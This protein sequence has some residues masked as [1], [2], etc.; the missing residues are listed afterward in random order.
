MEITD[1]AVLVSPEP[2]VSRSTQLMPESI[3]MYLAVKWSS[4]RRRRSDQ[5]VNDSA[6]ALQGTVVPWCDRNSRWN[7][8]QWYLISG[9]SSF[10]DTADAGI[11]LGTLQSDG[12]VTVD[13][14]ATRL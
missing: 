1:R 4:D 10:T 7:H 11:D 3:F 13:G 6:L 8:R 9:T 5:I 2:P 12:A 14:G